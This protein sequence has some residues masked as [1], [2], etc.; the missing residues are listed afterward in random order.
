MLNCP[1]KKVFITKNNK[2]IMKLLNKHRI[3][4]FL[5]GCFLTWLLLALNNLFW[6]IHNPFEY[7]WC[8]FDWC[9]RGI[10][11]IFYSIVMNFGD[12]ATIIAGG[13]LI[14]VFYK[15]FLKKE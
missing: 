9:S 15:K 14:P 1:F 11:P 10:L 6:N 5:I 13:V 4:L 12:W 3:K 2:N 8:F 7:E